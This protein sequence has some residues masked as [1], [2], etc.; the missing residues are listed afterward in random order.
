MFGRVRRRLDRLEF[1]AHNTMF[2]AQD[3][4]KLAK[5]LMDD[6]EQDGVTIEF[7]VFGKRIPIKVRIK[8]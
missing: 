3:L 1:N 5:D 4:I 2:D 7:E 6:I 8:P